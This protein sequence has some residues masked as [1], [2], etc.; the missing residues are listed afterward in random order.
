VLLGIDHLV[1]VVRDL[2]DASADL[3]RATGLES[4]AGGRH[5]ALGT[6]NRLAWLGDSYVELLLVEDEALARQAWLGGPAL[7]ALADGR[8]FVTWAVRS[9][10]LD[11]DVDRLR[12]T[13]PGWTSPVDGE[14][15]RDDGRIVRWR[16]A[17]PQRLGPLEP[18]LIERDPTSAEWTPEEV[19]ERAGGSPARLEVLDL[20]A[21]AM[22]ATIAALT[23]SLG[24]RFRPSLAGGGTRDANLGSQIVR[25]RPARAAADPP[26]VHLAMP[27]AERRTIE[28]LGCRWSIRPSG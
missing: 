16:L 10:A 13:A 3:E 9:D 20:P 2:D 6:A 26:T 7:A 23:G 14:R 22:P 21:Q 25:L 4:T 27:G 15:R 18:F 24:L 11:A 17:H 5:P 12:A 8:A 19:A 1:I 28:A